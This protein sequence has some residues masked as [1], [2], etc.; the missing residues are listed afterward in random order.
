MS[1]TWT[2]PEQ[3]MLALK[4]RELP[5]MQNYLGFYS[6]WLGGYFKEPWAMMLPMDDHGFHRGDGI[7]EAV[8]MTDRAYL[9]LVPHLQRLEQSALA[10]EMTLPWTLQ[11]IQDICIQLGRLCDTPMGILRLYVTRGPGGFSPNPY[12]AVGH[13]LYAAVTRMKPPPP[14]IYTK[15]IRAMLSTVEPKDERWSRIKS[16]NYLPNV[17]MKKECVDKGYDFALAVDSRGRVCEGATENLLILNAGG[18]ILVPRFDYTLR[19]TTVRTVMRLAEKLRPSGLVRDIRLADL[20]VED[21]R[22]AREA[23]FV[24]TTLGVLPVNSLDGKPIGSGGAG[25]LMQKLQAILI[26]HW[27]TDASLRTPY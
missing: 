16:C 4:A 5:H 11:E 22:T 2:D 18:D 25:E 20:T 12:E 23:A 27:S 7:F 1:A 19:G 24:G 8:R 17:M 26:E 9:D 13:Q 15:G 21:V 6:S 3:A 10:I 14:E